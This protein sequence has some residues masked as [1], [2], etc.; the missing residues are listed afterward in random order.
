MGQKASKRESN[1]ARSEEDA[2]QQKIRDGTTRV[3]NIFESNFNDDFY[4]GR[5]DA[6]TNFATPQ[7]EDQYG[8]AQKQLTYSLA[9]SGTLDSSIRGEKVGELQKLFDTNK[10]DIADKAL[11]NETEARNNVEGAR[12]DLIQTLSATGDA[13]GAANSALSRATALSQPTAFNPLSQLF[14]GF[15]STLG[16]Q[17]AQEKAEALSGGAY[18]A[19]YNT[20]LFGTPSSSVK[21]TG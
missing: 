1:I 7:L 19:K 16:Q 5:R 6:F 2:R 8:D 18:K 13:E 21:V 9:R 4:K 17:A 14:A 20:G 12:T 15:T 10:Q 3:G 11:A